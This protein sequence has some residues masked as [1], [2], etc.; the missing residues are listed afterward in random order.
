MWTRRN[1]HHTLDAAR[2]ER[3][4]GT[5]NGGPSDGRRHKPPKEVSLTDPQ[6]AGVARQGVDPFFAYDANYLIDNRAGIIVDAEGA[7]ANRSVEIAV[8]TENL[9]RVDEV[10]ESPR[11]RR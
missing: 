4:N 7:R 3:D 5:D 11:L 8:C 2:N 1:G 9:I 6:A 10:R